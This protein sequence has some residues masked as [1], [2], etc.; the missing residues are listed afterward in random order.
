MHAQSVPAHTTLRAF[1]VR[2][3]HSTRLLL[4]STLIP[5][6]GVLLA[7]LW[8]SVYLLFE[9]HTHG[10]ETLVAFSLYLQIRT[11]K[12]RERS[13]TRIKDYLSVTSTRCQSSLCL[14]PYSKSLMP[15]SLLPLVI[16]N[17]TITNLPL[18]ISTIS[19]LRQDKFHPGFAPV[20]R[21][22]AVSRQRNED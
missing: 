7:D 13:L 14:Y 21:I 8:T 4:E 17:I 11:Q 16:P 18:G 10:K 15:T 1:V 12:P 22:A 6:G 19:R 5:N 20:E 2:I 9:R 3:I